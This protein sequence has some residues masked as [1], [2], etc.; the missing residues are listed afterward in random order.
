MLEEAPVAIGVFCVNGTDAAIAFEENSPIDI[1]TNREREGFIS[2]VLAVKKRLQNT[3]RQE[4]LQRQ[5]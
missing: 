5:I 1:S 4:N 3:P 2:K